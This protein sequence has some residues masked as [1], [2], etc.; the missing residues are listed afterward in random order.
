M[1]NRIELHYA[2]HNLEALEYASEKLIVHKP[3]HMP[4]MF[5]SRILP[6][7]MLYL[8]PHFYPHQQ[9]LKEKHFTEGWTS[10][11]KRCPG[12]WA[13]GPGPPSPRHRCTLIGS[14]FSKPHKCWSGSGQRKWDPKCYAAVAI[15][16]SHSAPPSPWGLYQVI[17]APSGVQIRL[18]MTRQIMHWSQN[19]SHDYALRND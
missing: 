5:I 8:C 13:S 1:G 19:G 4:W 6:L 17:C 12:L 18:L 16:M 2:K 11:R 7:V 15:E 3:F 10:Q 9:T 14:H